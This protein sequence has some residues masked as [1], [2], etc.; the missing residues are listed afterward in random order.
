[1]ELCAKRWKL[2]GSILLPSLDSPRHWQFQCGEHRRRRAQ[3]AGR[4]THPHPVLVH[5]RSL[6]PPAPQPQ[7]VL[8][9]VDFL[10]PFDRVRC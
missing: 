9:A 5:L 8:L 2:K 3:S 7:G 6:Q 4:A 10:R 1:M